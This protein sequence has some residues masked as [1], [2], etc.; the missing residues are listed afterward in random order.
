MRLR[1]PTLEWKLGDEREYGTTR[2]VM[3]MHTTRNFP[4][5]PFFSHKLCISF[6]P[7]TV[8]LAYK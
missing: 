4:P 7:P 8:H 3:L 5:R 1:E 6:G 2:E